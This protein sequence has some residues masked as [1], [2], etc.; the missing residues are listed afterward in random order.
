MPL[1]RWYY[2]LAEKVADLVGRQY[3]TSCV[4]LKRNAFLLMHCTLCLGTASLLSFLLYIPQLTRDDPD[5]AV[6]Y[7]IAFAHFLFCAWGFITAAS[8]GLTLTVY[9]L[10]V[11]TSFV[12]AFA[13]CFFLRLPP[14]GT[15]AL[16]SAGLLQWVGENSVSATILL[17][18]SVCYA[19]ASHVVA[20]V[21][22]D[23]DAIPGWDTSPLKLTLPLMLAGMCNVVVC[24]D[25]SQRE[26]VVAEDREGELEHT[27]REMMEGLDQGGLPAVYDLLFTDEPCFLPQ[28]Y[29][30]LT[31]VY[32]AI[33]R[34]T[35]ESGGFFDTMI[36]EGLDALLP[37]SVES[38]D[39]T[40]PHEAS[41][42]T[43]Q[44]ADPKDGGF[45]CREVTMDEAH[46]FQ[47]M[48]PRTTWENRMSISEGSPL[49]TMMPEMMSWKSRT[50]K[51]MAERVS[52]FAID[53]NNNAKEKEAKEAK[54]AKDKEAKEAKEASIR[55]SIKESIEKSLKAHATASQVPSPA[56]GLSPSSASGGLTQAVAAAMQPV[57][58][59]EEPPKIPGGISGGIRENRSM[60]S[61]V[62]SQANSLLSDTPG[63]SVAV[64]NTRKNPQRMASVDR[65]VFESLDKMSSPIS[66]SLVGTAVPAQAT[67]L[68]SHTLATAS[69]PNDSLASKA[70]ARKLSGNPLGNPLDSVKSRRP[71]TQT[72]RREANMQRFTSFARMM[73]PIS[74]LTKRP[75]NTAPRERPVAPPRMSISGSGEGMPVVLTVQNTVTRL[76]TVLQLNIDVKHDVLN[77]QGKYLNLLWNVIADIVVTC[78]AT[79]LS[80][81]GYELLLGWGVYKEEKDH[82]NRACECAL[83][84]GQKLFD[85]AD[86]EWW[87]VAISSG[88]MQSRIQPFGK[89][90]FQANVGVPLT[91][92]QCLTSLSKVLRCHVLITQAAKEAVRTDD[93]QVQIVDIIPFDITRPLEDR[94][95]RTI[96]IYSLSSAETKR[97]LGFY[98]KAFSLFSIGKFQACL[99]Q[100]D[101]DPVSDLQSMRL[102]MMCTAA[103]SPHPP[104]AASI[105]PIPYF[106]H[107]GNAWKDYEEQAASCEMAKTDGTTMEETELFAVNIGERVSD[108]RQTESDA[109]ALRESIRHTIVGES[110][111]A[112]DG[113]QRS[114]SSHS[115]GVP[116]SFLDNNN[117]RQKRSER[118]LGKGAFG[119]VWLG[120]NPSGALTALK[121]VKLPDDHT[122]KDMKRRKLKAPAQDGGEPANPDDPVSSLITEIV[123]LSK[124]S[125]E[126]IVSYKGYGIA[127]NHVVI[128]MECVLGGSL[129]DLIHQFGA[130]ERQS[131]MRYASCMLQ[132]LQYLH[133]N[134]VVHRDFKPANV[135]MGN[136]GVCKI[137]DFG[138]SQ[139]IGDATSPIQAV[140]TPLYMSPEAAQGIGGKESDVW[141]FGL[142]V[143]EMFHGTTLYSDEDRSIGAM[144]FVKR[145][146]TDE[147]F[148]PDLTHLMIDSSDCCDFILQSITRCADQRPT[149]AEL[150]RHS[151][152][153]GV[154]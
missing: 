120:M 142:T 48:M 83:W 93:F 143:A 119:S 51:K 3:M 80:L 56:G 15:L 99:S 115:V 132:G 63:T 2:R 150:L 131:L 38:I 116:T 135:L 26:V 47:R 95:L 96:N 110:L 106:R 140:G 45:I 81:S 23:A 11:A 94:M 141:S 79:P 91:Q 22:G 59:V 100:L 102:R 43:A 149:C 125:H 36:G 77:P 144:L 84:L 12:F 19:V 111:R 69:N 60:T 153:M 13:E 88:T 127:G 64:A 122:C 66:T 55:D 39:H 103:I 123:L 134:G 89:L 61:S 41:E 121:F 109:T 10:W 67:E 58:S 138:A 71:S 137:T 118:M 25:V 129:S 37:V 31:E 32:E 50:V 117:D 113:L 21:A 62:G 35:R 139:M 148:G 90:R 151:F 75:S 1:A 70:A 87:S 24:F 128:C 86:L 18:L 65:G 124:L 97:D 5:G 105:Y 42:A 98:N 16:F 28:Y 44:D 101:L 52:A 76:A 49:T 46:H 6:S 146:A 73:G 54:E 9:R 57:P 4:A 33:K 130:L 92:V 112:N 72:A 133:A 126:N 82:A 53:T 145:L 154:S 8:G 85:N 108:R 114:D 34:A 147:N 27:I 29:E 40:D 107:C 20:D 104:D 14:S 74:K 152:L 7:L 68:Y 17:F 30:L 136:D 78:G